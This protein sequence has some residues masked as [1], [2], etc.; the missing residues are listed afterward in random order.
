MKIVFFG[1]SDFSVLP[2]EFCLK[3]AHQL[4]AVVTTPDRPKGRGLH[5]QANPLKEC[6]KKAGVLTFD[7]ESLKDPEIKENIVALEP[8]LFIVASYGKLIP[9]SWLE[10]PKIAP[11]NIHPSL[12]PK[13][14]GAAP[15][16]W[17][18]LNG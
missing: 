10:I 7:P 16:A 5:L 9:S 14:R 2:F 6:A 18:I 4:V 11:W 15:I 17:Q 3:S 12:L 1:S 13:Y 8:D